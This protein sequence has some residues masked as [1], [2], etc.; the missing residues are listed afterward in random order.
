M[1]SLNN[2]I[3]N[4]ETTLRVNNILNKYRKR[5]KFELFQDDQNYS[6]L[7]Y[8]RKFLA[9]VL[10]HHLFIQYDSFPGDFRGRNFRISL[11]KSADYHEVIFNLNEDSEHLLTSLMIKELGHSFDLIKKANAY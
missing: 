1:N 10:F 6:L 2:T 11:V 8:R 7:I 5:I 3:K 9:D 4:I